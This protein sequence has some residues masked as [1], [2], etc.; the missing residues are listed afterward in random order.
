MTQES[1]GGVSLRL[2]DPCSHPPSPR[3]LET[4][5]GCSCHSD[6]TLN[7]RESRGDGRHKE[8]CHYVGC[9]DEWT[10]RSPCSK[11]PRS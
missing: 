5:D 2:S 7:R 9:S 8:R 11:V 4:K 3:V 10:P 1:R 6:P